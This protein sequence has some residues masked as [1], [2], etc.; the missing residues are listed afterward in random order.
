M[1]TWAQARHIQVTGA[2]NGACKAGFHTDPEAYHHDDN[3]ADKVTFVVEVLG[4]SEVERK[5]TN[6]G[7]YDHASEG[8][9]EG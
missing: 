1:F 8:E 6:P 9:H 2:D 5:T 3:Y 4:S 7:W